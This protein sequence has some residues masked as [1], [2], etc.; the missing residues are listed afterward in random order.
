MSLR[1]RLVA[2]LLVIG[3]VLIGAGV[4]VAGLIR[5]ALV[6]QVDRQLER[7]APPL[8]I[9]RR[10]VRARSPSFGGRVGTNTEDRFTELYFAVRR[11]VKAFACSVRPSVRSRLPT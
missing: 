2:A 11:P 8:G 10:R 4:A 5:G 9:V 7:A 3:V 1:H 6:D